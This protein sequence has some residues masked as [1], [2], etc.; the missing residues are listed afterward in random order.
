MAP[1][2]CLVGELR[3]G[4]L[5]NCCTLFPLCLCRRLSV[6]RRERK[7]ISE[8]ACRSVLLC[9]FCIELE[10]VGIHMNCYYK[11]V[12]KSESKRKTWTWTLHMPVST[13]INTLSSRMSVFL[14]LPG[15]VTH[16][17][18]GRSHGSP[19]RLPFRSHVCSQCFCYKVERRMD[20][21]R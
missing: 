17:W 15:M 21:Q 18:W 1:L 19:F 4:K 5:F 10:R 11:H 9:I 2:V 20:A 16:L 6:H 12:Y 8:N 13:G 14:V 3:W 7:C